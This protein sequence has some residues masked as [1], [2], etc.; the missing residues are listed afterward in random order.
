L[1]KTELTI[2]AEFNSVA[3][4][5]NLIEKIGFRYA[6]TTKT[7]HATK[8]AVEEVVTNI[9]RHG[10]INTMD[11]KITIQIQ[12]RAYSLG[13]V[14][15]DQG[16]SFD[17]KQVNN[18]NIAH[19]IDI[20][21]RGGLGIFMIRKLVDEFQYLVTDRGNEIH[22]IK[23]RDG[24]HKSSLRNFIQLLKTPSKLKIFLPMYLDCRINM[25]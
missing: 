6:F 12:V 13:I 21:K 14:L 11:G 15:I 20:G 2:P 19:Y 22:L 24:Y 16:P 10:Y 1:K 8:L 4:I 7:I 5:R 3:P 18:P 25:Q 23:Y 17:P 9:I